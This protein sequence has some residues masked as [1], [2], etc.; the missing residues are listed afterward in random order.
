MRYIERSDLPID[1]NRCENAIPLVVSRKRWFSADTPAAAHASAVIYSLIETASAYG[2]KLYTW[3]RRAL[4][5]FAS[6][7]VRRGHI[8]VLAV[9]SLSP[10]FSQRNAP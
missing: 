9:E 4:R 7:P 8:R 1:D 5:E 2:L 3:M 10:R 6:R